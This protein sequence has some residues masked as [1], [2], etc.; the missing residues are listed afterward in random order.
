MFIVFVHYIRS[1]EELE[2]HLADHRRF[3]DEQYAAGHFLASGPRVPR[4]GGIVLA[5]T[6][7]REELE[8]VL[9]ADPF[10]TAGVAEYEILEFTPTKYRPEL[11]A[12]L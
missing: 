9:A 5:R 6:A 7:T 10:R 1:L 4:T 11:G 2:A 8:L 12:L 3:L